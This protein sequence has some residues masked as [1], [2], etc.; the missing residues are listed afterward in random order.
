ML[1]AMLPRNQNG[2]ALRPDEYAVQQLKKFNLN[3]DEPKVVE[4]FFYFPTKALAEKASEEITSEGCDVTIELGDE[5]SSWLCFATKQ[6]IPSSEEL[7]RL[8]KVFEA[9]AA[10]YK[11]EYDGWGTG[12]INEGNV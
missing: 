9:I 7:D 12:F 8:R 1:N 3:F 10:K 11:G 6:M 5:N 2:K 4:F